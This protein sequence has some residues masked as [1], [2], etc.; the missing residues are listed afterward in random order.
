[1]SRTAPTHTAFA[2]WSG[3]P[4]IAALISKAPSSNMTDRPHTPFRTMLIRIVK[5]T[6]R[7]EE[8][9]R[10]QELFEGWKP[11]IRAFPGC[12]HLELLHD[13]KDPRIFFT[14][15][16]WE[17]PGDLEAYR[18]S[19]VFASVWPVVKDLFAAPAEAWSVAR[20]HH[21]P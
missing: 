8:V 12:L 3:C 14:Y 10:F 19:D 11:R 9:G 15:S 7:P 17:C 2:G 18:V 13:V 1:M 6:F 16:H 4:T 5:M 21:L 20:E